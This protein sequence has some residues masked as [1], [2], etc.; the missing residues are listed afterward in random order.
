[1][2]HLRLFVAHCVADER[3]DRLH[4]DERQHLHE[5]VLQHVA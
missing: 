4:G 2:E 3:R 1:M 5:V